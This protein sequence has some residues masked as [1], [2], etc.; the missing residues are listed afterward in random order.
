VCG[1]QYVHR[2]QQLF[3]AIQTQTPFPQIRSQSRFVTQLDEQQGGFTCVSVVSGGRPEAEAS[4]HMAFSA[5]SATRAGL[6]TGRAVLEGAEVTIAA[7][8]TAMTTEVPRASNEVLLLI[9][10]T[11]SFRDIAHHRRFG[12]R[13]VKPLYCGG[14]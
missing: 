7:A 8:K 9:G 3:V 10:F 5:L 11:S 6:P 1:D 4:A 12:G 2:L 13:A 14:G